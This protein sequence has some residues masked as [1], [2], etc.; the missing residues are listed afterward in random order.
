MLADKPGAHKRRRTYTGGAPPL[1]RRSTDCSHAP[2]ME[3][4]SRK[5][6]E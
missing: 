5:E 4:D 3:N 2:G 6:L 1:D